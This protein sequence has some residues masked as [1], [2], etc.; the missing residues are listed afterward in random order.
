VDSL[1]TV[2][3]PPWKNPPPTTAAAAA[4]AAASAA[5][6]GSKL[7]GQPRY[8]NQIKSNHV[9]CRKQGSYLKKKKNV[10]AE[11]GQDIRPSVQRRRFRRPAAQVP[12]ANEA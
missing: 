10:S 4:A 8:S 1:S 9:Y 6:I 11:C 5:V 3:D 7:V 2:N 12:T